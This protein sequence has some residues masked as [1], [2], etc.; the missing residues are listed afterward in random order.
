MGFS[1]KLAENFENPILS[2][3][4]TPIL[5]LV[6]TSTGPETHLSVLKTLDRQSISATLTKYSR[7]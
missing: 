4:F 6:G 2:R 3:Q 5:T 1:K 7:F